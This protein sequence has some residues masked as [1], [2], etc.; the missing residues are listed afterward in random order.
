[1]TSFLLSFFPKRKGHKDRAP[2]RRG[3]NS[4]SRRVLERKEIT[5]EIYIFISI[6]REFST[7]SAQIF[8]PKQLGKKQE[9]TKGVTCKPTYSN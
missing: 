8:F 9:I 6:Y 5:I 3:M 1:M 4:N 7:I 2:R